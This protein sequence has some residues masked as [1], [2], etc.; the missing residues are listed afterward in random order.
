MS[1]AWFC[2]VWFCLA[3]RLGAVIIFERVD[4]VTD[5]AVMRLNFNIRNIT[6]RL[7]LS[8]DLQ[9]LKEIDGQLMVSSAV[10][11]QSYTQKK[12]YRPG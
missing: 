3:Q 7:S 6:G 4:F 12:K 1:N 11:W 5:P 10:I 9:L 2:L 8:L